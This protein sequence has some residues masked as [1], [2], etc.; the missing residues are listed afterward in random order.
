[1]G[2]LADVPEHVLLS[3]DERAA[4]LYL[5]ASPLLM[6]KGVERFISTAD[7]SVDWSALRRE[8]EVWSHGER[9]LLQLAAHLWNDSNP[10]PSIMELIQTLSDTNFSCAMEAIQARRGNLP[11]WVMRNV[12]RTAHDLPRGR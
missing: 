6:R 11:T 7:Y 8:A 12:L 10:S 9:L 3:D 5:M 2:V 4:V 1:M